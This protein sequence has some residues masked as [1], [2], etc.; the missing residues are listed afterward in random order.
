MSRFVLVDVRIMS[1]V[2]PIQ[3]NWDH[4]QREREKDTHSQNKKKMEE[5]SY[6]AVYQ[7]PFSIALAVV[8]C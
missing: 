4:T 2:V 7:F 3:M 5:K 1:V 6:D 8:K